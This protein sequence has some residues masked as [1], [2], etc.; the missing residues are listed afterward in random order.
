[1][2]E[3]SYCLIHWPPQLYWLAFFHALHHYPNDCNDIFESER[4]S[5]YADTLLKIDLC[6]CMRL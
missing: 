2:N 6:Q 4:R 5:D 1:M 3:L